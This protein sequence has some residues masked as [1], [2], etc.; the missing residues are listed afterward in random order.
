MNLHIPAIVAV[1][2]EHVLDRY[3]STPTRVCNVFFSAFLDD[4]LARFEI[5]DHLIELSCDLRLLGL[6]LFR[7]L[8]ENCIARFAALE[9]SPYQ[10]SRFIEPVITLVAEIQQYRF[11]CEMGG[12]YVGRS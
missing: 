10:G 3:S 9:C 5:F 11:S 4:E 8:I 6:V 1:M 7:E 12:E 2:E